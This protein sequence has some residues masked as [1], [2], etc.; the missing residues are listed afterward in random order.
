MSK[1]LSSR[2]DGPTKSI[3]LPFCITAKMNKPFEE[4][5]DVNRNSFF[6]LEETIQM[7]RSQKRGS[8]LC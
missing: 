1:Q 4:I 5:Q 3:L 7:Q 8:E 6:F 2:A